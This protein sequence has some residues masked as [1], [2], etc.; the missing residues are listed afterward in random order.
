M[1]LTHWMLAGLLAC[2]GN[3]WAAGA[4][5]GQWEFSVKTSVEGM[6]PSQHPLKLKKCLS[7]QDVANPL[8]L[9]PL[10]PGATPEGCTLGE[11]KLNGNK[12]S[13]SMSCPGMPSVSTSGEATIGAASITGSAHSKLDAVSYKKQLEQQ[14]SGKRLGKCE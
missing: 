8:K 11:Q 12:L 3:V 9:L 10:A 2:V 13:Y 7:A 4:E 1:K 6:P 14:Y 5:P